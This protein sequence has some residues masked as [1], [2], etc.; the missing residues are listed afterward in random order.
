MKAIMSQRNIS[1]RVL[2]VSYNFPPVGGAGVQRVTKFVKYLPQFGWEPTVLTTE[3]PS[4]PVFDESL[5]ADIPPQT[6]VVKARTLEPGYALKRIVSGSNE[7]LARNASE[8]FE[9]SNNPSLARRARVTAKSFAKQTLRGVANFLLQPDPQVLWNSQAIEAGLRVLGQRKHDAIFVTAPPFSSFLIGAELA[10]RTG[11]PLVLDYRDEWSISNS[12]LENKRLGWLSRTW[13]QHQQSL[14]VRAASALIATT[15]HSA[16]SLQAVARVASSRP[17][18]THIYNGF[19]ADDFN[20]RSQPQ[21]DPLLESSSD[22][23]Q[24]YKLAY[25]GTLWNLTSVEP[26]VRA[27]RLLGEQSPDLAAR[28]ELHFVG[29]RTAAQDEWLDQLGSLPCRVV[30]QPYLD[31]AAAIRLMQS[32]DGLCLLLS[33]LPEAG[34]V[35]P[36]KLFEYLAVR[37]PMFAVVPPGEVSSML[38]DCPFAFVHSPSDV[39]GLAQRLGDEI[40]RHRLGVAL[41]SGM[42]DSSRFERSRQAEQLAEL[43]NRVSVVG[44][45]SQADDARSN[46]GD[47]PNQSVAPVRLGSR[48]Y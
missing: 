12:Y 45:P 40:E 37:R 42:W 44:Q 10:R 47:I 27:V 14:V 11:L 30:R 25:V 43:L 17:L 41:P 39:T 9:N 15:R 29:R 20:D 6:V 23:S 5:L 38:E 18:V 16:E 22:P 2:V 8:G 1:K 31:H 32:A 13:Q 19:D 7:T 33:D 48:T 4:V 28:L 24:P 35:V 26:I 46:V 21:P 3:N 36:A 34:R